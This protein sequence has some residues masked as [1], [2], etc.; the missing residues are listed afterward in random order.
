VERASARLS[1]AIDFGL[2]AQQPL[3]QFYAA[4]PA[5]LAARGVPPAAI[6]ATIASI[7]A[8]YAAAGFVP[9]GSDGVLE[10]S[11]DDWDVGFTLGALFEY[12]KRGNDTG[13]LQEGRIG[14]SYRSPMQ[15]KLSGNADFRRVPLITAP[16]AAVQFPNP[17]A[18]Q[19]IFFSQ[20]ATAT[21]DLPDVFHFSVYQRFARQ[22]A[23]MGDITWTRWN[24]LQ[25]VPIVFSNATTPSNVLN[26]NY[27]DARRYA[28]GLEW[29]A[30][31]K[32]TLRTGFA[33]DETPIRSAEFRTPRI[34]DNNRY[35]LSAG[36]KWSPTSCMDIDLGYAH[37]FVQEPRSDVI[38]SQ[39]HE[40]IGRY[41]A[42][43]NV[44]SASVTFKWGGPRGRAESTHQEAKDNSYRK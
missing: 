28:I 5:A 37:L 18:L 32:F 7:Q 26:I 34:P 17:G 20:D 40:L 8:A 1:Q 24:R 42:Q 43:V 11:G 19:A 12:L 13:F 39:G 29:Y 33:Y 10:L 3:G 38:D 27:D 6:P 31:P 16:G 21:L 30:C 36:V 23:V 4:L 35:F 2:I 9:G 22:F 41:D 14:F 25:D 44:V 15:Q